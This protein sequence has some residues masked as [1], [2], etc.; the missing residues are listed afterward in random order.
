M[1][2]TCISGSR[3][4]GSFAERGNTT[5]A[6]GS[7]EWLI[8]ATSGETHTPSGANDGEVSVIE[9]VVNYAGK[10][11]LAM[12]IKRGSGQAHP[13]YQIDNAGD[14]LDAERDEFVRVRN[15]QVA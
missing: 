11:L 10:G 3:L 12:K 2:T 9:F 7:H 4:T 6:F 15:V 13:R 1:A 8:S 5:T 14:A